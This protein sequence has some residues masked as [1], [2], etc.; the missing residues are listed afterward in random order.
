MFS[1]S[2]EGKVGAW[3]ILILLL[4]LCRSHEFLISR[5]VLGTRSAAARWA[6]RDHCR[7][8][9]RRVSLELETS[10]ICV[11]SQNALCLV[12]SDTPQTIHM[13]ADVRV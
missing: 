10:V 9:S 8:P 2:R 5:V 11:L 12:C 13:V 6:N 7:F 3:N 4:S 1:R